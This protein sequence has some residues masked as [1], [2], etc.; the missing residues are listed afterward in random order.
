MI[1][2]MV[3]AYD[4]GAEFIQFCGGES[5]GV[6]AALA[7]RPLIEPRLVEEGRVVRGSRVGPCVRKAC[8]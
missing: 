7:D 2:H 1:S 3:M 4:A 8:T 5:L 6:S